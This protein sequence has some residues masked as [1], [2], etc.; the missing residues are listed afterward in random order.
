MKT[1]RY[2]SSNMQSGEK[3]FDFRRGSFLAKGGERGRIRE[4]W[5][6][7][8]GCKMLRTGGSGQGRGYW[9]KT[10]ETV[11]YGAAR[12]ERVLKGVGERNLKMRAMGKNRRSSS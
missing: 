4:G 9:R 1:T 12:L 5:K 6:V 2:I 10:I 11:G 3:G 8:T 7:F